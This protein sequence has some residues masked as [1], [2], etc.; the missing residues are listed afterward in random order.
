MVRAGLRL[1]GENAMLRLCG[2]KVSAGEIRMLFISYS[3]T[4]NAAYV[5]GK[6]LLLYVQSV[7]C[8]LF[9]AER[10]LHVSGWGRG[11]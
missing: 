9:M 11:G 3:E 7:A 2:E 8:I 5:A 6:R 1:V 10:N 4:A